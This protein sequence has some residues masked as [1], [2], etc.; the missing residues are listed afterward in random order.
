MHPYLI[1]LLLCAVAAAAI[2]YRTVPVPQRVQARNK[3]LLFGG[4]GIVAVLLVSGRLHPLFAVVAAL[5]PVALRLLTLAQA[6]NSF[7]SFRQRATGSARP[8]SGQTSD[9]ETRFLRMS[10]DHDSGE[11]DG[12]ILEG[13]LKGRRLG[14]LNLAS[15]LVLLAT[16]RAADPK[17]AAVLEA[18]LE[19]VHGDTWRD[20]EDAGDDGQSSGPQTMSLDEARQILEIEAGATRE[21]IIQA[22]R[23]LMQKMHPD[24]GGS[25]FLAAKINQAKQTLLNSL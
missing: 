4:L 24:R 14:E 11:L 21:D 5:V 23:R 15:L 25:T 9:V 7:K 10:L 1:V 6:A 3:L 18:Y 8:A 13:P 22:H 19:R 12:V 17:S 20:G 2:W 16:C